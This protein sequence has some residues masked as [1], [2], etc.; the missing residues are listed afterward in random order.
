MEMKLASLMGN[1]WQRNAINRNDQLKCIII[2]ERYQCPFNS[3]LL[4]FCWTLL[5]PVCCLSFRPK[6]SSGYYTHKG[7][8]Q[9]DAGRVYTASVTGIYCIGDIS[10]HWL[11]TSAR[12]LLKLITLPHK[13][14]IRSLQDC[15]VSIASSGRR[16][17]G[18]TPDS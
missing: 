18:K 17:R 12:H 2:C 10:Q 8:S 4:P 3:H 14:Y 6:C 15:R 7:G 5:I 1:D 9:Y 11:D 13:L 16:V